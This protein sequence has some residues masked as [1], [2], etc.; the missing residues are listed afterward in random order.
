M[1]FSYHY[2]ETAEAKYKWKLYKSCRY[3]PFSLKETMTDKATYQMLAARVL[4]SSVT[5]Q[6]FLSLISVECGQEVS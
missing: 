6:V 3:P 5:S 2:E 4:E 1:Q